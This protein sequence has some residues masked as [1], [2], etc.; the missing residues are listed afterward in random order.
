MNRP[1]RLHTRYP[2]RQRI[3]LRRANGKGSAVLLAGDISEG[4]LFAITE[5]AVEI[6]RDDAECRRL[7]HSVGT[8]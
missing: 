2:L 3:V 6:D 4:G 7:M 1:R 8:G 5:Q